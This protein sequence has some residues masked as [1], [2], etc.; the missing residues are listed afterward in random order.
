MSEHMS[1]NYRE[2]ILSKLT[3]LGKSSKYISVTNYCNK[4]K[5]AFK[6]CE[7]CLFDQDRTIKLSWLS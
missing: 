7:F 4:P 3:M 6:N 1:I 5:Q 2:A